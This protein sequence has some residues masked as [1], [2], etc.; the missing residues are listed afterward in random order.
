MD[1]PMR[2]RRQAVRNDTDA[3]AY[4]PCDRPRG[5]KGGTSAY[6]PAHQSRM[7]LGQNMDAPILD[8]RHGTVH[9][10][11]VRRLPDEFSDECWEWPGGRTKKDDD[12]YGLIRRGGKDE[13]T[14]RVTNIVHEIFIGPVPAEHNVVRHICDNPPCV[15]PRHLISG[16]R[17]DNM[18]DKTLR[19]RAAMKLTPDAVRAI[20]ADP[21][22]CKRVAR[23]FGVT[24]STI[25]SVRKRRT[26]AWVED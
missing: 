26:W 12:G 7:R 21:R 2:P 9:E 3:C 19:G 1:A 6:C 16:T 8:K 15:N 13:G 20:R 18:V 24:P 23:D 4:P 5:G 11:V 17:T 14:V 25:K 22:G 10:R